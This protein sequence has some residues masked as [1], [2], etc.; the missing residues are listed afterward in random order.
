MDYAAKIILDSV[1]P[2]GQTLTTSQLTYPR[3]IHAE[4][5]TH[6]EFSRNASS[7]RAIPVQKMIEQVRLSPAMPVHWGQNQSGMQARS[8]LPADQR[9]QAETL[10]LD[11][12]EE[13]ANFAEGMMALG[14]HKQVANRI[15]EPFQWMHAIVT[16]TSH[17]NFDGLRLHADADPNIYRLAE[18][19]AEARLAS[20]PQHLVHGQWHL[21]YIRPADVVNV[22]NRLKYRRITRDEPSSDQINHMLAQISAARCARVSYLTHDGQEPTIE[23]DLELYER[24][25]GS[26]PIHA[27][28]LEHQATP[29]ATSMA[30]EPCGKPYMDWA[31]PQLHGNLTGW[32]QFRK[33]HDHEYIRH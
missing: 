33:F 12:A 18:V 17:T 1:G 23:K 10:W 31:N 7:S 29:D 13:A 27:S 28:P 11:A 9:I 26:Q 8:E 4:F 2:D 19:W 32:Q 30:Y 24:L 6:R 15:L 25:A 21:P 16:T 3:F 20:K 14:L 5:M 22:R